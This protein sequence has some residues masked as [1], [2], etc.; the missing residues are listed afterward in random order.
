MARARTVSTRVQI[1]H[2]KPGH[3]ISASKA[4]GVH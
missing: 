1:S 4:W 3:C 2:A